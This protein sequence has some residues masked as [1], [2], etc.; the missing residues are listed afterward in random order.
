[1]RNGSASGRPSFGCRRP[2]GKGF[3]PTSTASAANVNTADPKGL[4][5]SDRK[6]KILIFVI[7]IILV[8]VPFQMM[9]GPIHDWLMLHT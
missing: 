8:T 6:I 3:E 4:R 2:D 7:V 1:V 5:V 9:H